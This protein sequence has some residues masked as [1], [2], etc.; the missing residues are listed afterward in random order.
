M[1][2]AFPSDGGTFDTE[3]ASR[4]NMLESFYYIT[5]WQTEHIRD[6]KSFLL[7]SGA[8]TFVFGSKKRVD[9]NDYVERYVDYIIENDVELFFEM[10]IDKLVGYER[11]K[12][13]RSYIERRTGKQSIPVFHLERGKDEWLRMCDEYSYVAIGGIAVAEGRRK[14]EPY[15]PWF[16]SEAH[17]RGAKVHGL[18][19]TNLSNLPKT[20]FDSVDSSAWLYGNR[21]GFVYR[22]DG[23][24][25]RKINVPKGKKLNSREVAQHNFIEWVRMGES[26][27][28]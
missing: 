28:R 3:V 16:T 23:R 4:V 14:L 8:F 12:E 13:I 27:E 1:S 17:K 15:I 10:D 26:L 20:G 18:G 21:G 6:F 9:I 24:E 11:V 7:D 5:D 22:W 2:W 19:Y 25:M